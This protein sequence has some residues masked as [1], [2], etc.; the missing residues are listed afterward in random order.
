MK[1]RTVVA[2]GAKG[3]WEKRA[4]AAAT[5]RLLCRR[6]ALAAILLAGLLALLGR[7]PAVAH[8]AEKGGD[9][10]SSAGPAPPLCGQ[11]DD[12]KVHVP[13]DWNTFRPP[14]VGQS[15]IDP[16]FGC[17]VTR[18]TD[19]SA[20]EPLPDGRHPGLVHYY[21]TWSPLNAGDS[22]L[23]IAALNGAW[24]IIDTKA[25]TVIAPTAM[26][27]MNNGH[28]VWDAA[29]GSVF[30]YARGEALYRGT[31]N[32]RSVDS[33]E[34]HRFQEYQGVISPDAADLSQDGDHIALVGE[35]ADRRLDI[36]VW[37]LR[38]QAKTSL[39]T[40]TC[41]SA[42]SIIATQQPGCVHKLQLTADNLLSIQFAQD[43]S[44]P[45]QGVRLWDG[46]ALVHW[47]DATNHY[48]TGEDFQGRP[49]F[50]AVGNASTLA[51]L[52]NSCRSGWGLEVRR[53]DEVPSAAC[54]LDHAPAWHVSYRGG[55]SQPWAALS[56]FDTRAQG[57]EYFS[58]DARFEAPSSENWPLYEDEIVLASVDGSAVYRLAQAR[59]RSAESYWSQPHAAISRDG[60]Y[61]VF[62]SNMAHPD[63]CPANMLAAQECTDVYLIQVR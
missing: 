31:V 32:G 27:A 37:S 29:N 25:Q 5:R 13:A 46:H 63:G 40:T 8:L 43:G 16:V 55:P 35:R 42:G 56:F 17:R 7:I 12:R 54:L 22:L 57:P 18:L 34:L 47:Q 23:L 3:G 15:Y 20:A 19:S 1:G 28:P 4:G 9:A 58:Q 14:R 61:V 52:Q 24:R 2:P 53:Q 10:A 49:V 62:T 36:F 26:P 50:I 44:G 51:G 6:L 48:D 38:Q 45:E 11:R 59:S 30:Y 41:E 33:A 60:R 21:S 39:Y